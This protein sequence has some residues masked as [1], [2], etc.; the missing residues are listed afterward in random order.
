MEVHRIVVAISKHIVSNKALPGTRAAVRIDKPADI[1]IVISAL[2]IVKL[3]I[4]IVVIP[5]IPQGIHIRHGTRDILG[6]AVWVVMIA[7][8]LVSRAVDQ[9]GYI[10][11]SVGNVVIGNWAD[12][13]VGVC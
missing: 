8:H 2:Q 10:P 5:T 4:R 11:L 9:L 7:G 3:C 1:S 12:G 13:T 6:F